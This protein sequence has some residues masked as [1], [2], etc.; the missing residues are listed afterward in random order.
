MEL[1]VIP[2]TSGLH[3]AK[4]FKYQL[5]LAHMVLSK[6]DYTNQYA[7]MALEGSKIILDNSLYELNCAMSTED[8]TTACMRLGGVYE[9]ILPDSFRSA[10][11]T[12]HKT[13]LFL[14]HVEHMSDIKSL[15]ERNFVVPH[16][17]S[18]REWLKCFDW[19]SSQPYAHTIG[20]PKILD[21]IWAGGR[22]GCCLFLEQTG[23]IDPTKQYHCLGIRNDPMEALLLSRFK[24][25]RSLDTA[26]PIHAGLQNVKFSNR[27]GLL[28]R[29]TKR[30]ENYFDRSTEEYLDLINHN[31]SL[32]QEWCQGIY[33]G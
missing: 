14:K 2:P 32:L 5:A 3:L 4:P 20:L 30:P 24:W 13:E 9:L 1:C 26:L 21:D 6:D 12:I 23:R 28:D 22:V 15:W 11:E 16:G 8:L 10:E 18:M 29:R 25:I 7:T 27:Y 33:N 31:I 17:S 19:F